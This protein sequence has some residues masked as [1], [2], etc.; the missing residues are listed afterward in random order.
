MPA[1][2][3]LTCLC[4]HRAG[5]DKENFRDTIASASHAITYDAAGGPKDVVRDSITLVVS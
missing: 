4:F 5:Q 2:V 1:S 3:Q